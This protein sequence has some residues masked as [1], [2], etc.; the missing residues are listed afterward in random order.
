MG[1]SSE[2]LGSFEML[3]VERDVKSRVYILVQG[4]KRLS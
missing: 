4:L 1:I 2:A 3:Q